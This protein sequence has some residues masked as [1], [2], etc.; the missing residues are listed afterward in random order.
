M[1]L[2]K[3]CSQVREGE[4]FVFRRSGYRAKVRALRPGR[5][6]VPVEVIEKRH[7]DPG[8]VKETDWKFNASS[9]ELN[10]A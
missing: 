9:A 2:G 3:K 10:P 7:D 6:F 4:V 5:K 8:W 1:C